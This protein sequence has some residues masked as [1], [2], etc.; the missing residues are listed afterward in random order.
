MW[1]ERRGFGSPRCKFTKKSP[2]NSYKTYKSYIISGG[3]GGVRES[4]RAVR[5][6]RRTHDWN[7]VSE[8]GTEQFEPRIFA[9]DF[10]GKGAVGYCQ[11][12][13]VS[14]EGKFR[15]QA[16]GCGLALHDVDCVAD[17][18]G[19]MSEP[20]HHRRVL[21]YDYCL[22]GKLQRRSYPRGGSGGVHALHEYLSVEVD[23]LGKDVF[24]GGVGGL[25][26]VGHNEVIAPLAQARS[27]RRPGA[28]ARR[29]RP[30]LG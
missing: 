4:R 28:P 3:A 15:Q 25:G 18:V 23:G 27:G 11:R 24:L 20:R 8:T 22:P 12:Y 13:G 6:G 29:L 10:L 2:Y 17:F 30:R 9:G 19:Q 7:W 26:Q 1:V 16:F 5:S 21:W 14:S